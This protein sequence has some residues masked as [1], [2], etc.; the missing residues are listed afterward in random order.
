MDKILQKLKSAFQE[1]SGYTKDELKSGLTA[2]GHKRDKKQIDS[3]ASNPNLK[4]ADTMEYK[5]YK[6][7]EWPTGTR[8]FSNIQIVLKDGSLVG[9]FKNIKEAKQYIDSGKIKRHEVKSEKIESADMSSIINNLK[10]CPDNKL[11]PVDLYRGLLDIAYNKE[12]LNTN[13]LLKKFGRYTAKQWKDYLKQKKIMAEV[14]NPFEEDSGYTEE[15]WKKLD[16]KTKEQYLE[17]HPNSK[18]AEKKESVKP[19]KKD[20]SKDIQE[21]TDETMTTKEAKE[22]WRDYHTTDPILVDY[23]SFEDWYKESKE[24]G[25]IKDDKP[26]QEDNNSLE[27]VDDT[28]TTEEAKQYWKENHNSDP[29]LV[30]YDSFEDWYKESKE[31]GYIKDKPIEKDSSKDVHEEK[32]DQYEARKSFADKLSKKFGADYSKYISKDKPYENINGQEEYNDA[33]KKD[34]NTK[35]IFNLSNADME[36]SNKYN[37]FLDYIA[38]DPQYTACQEILIKTVSK[39]PKTFQKVYK[40]AEKLRDKKIQELGYKTRGDLAS[41]LAEENR[42]NQQKIIHNN[43][44][45]DTNTL[46]DYFLDPD[47]ENFERKY[48]TTNPLAGFE[49]MPAEKQKDLVERASVIRNNYGRSEYWQEVTRPA[50]KYYFKIDPNK[51][52]QEGLKKL[53]KGGMS[54]EEFCEKYKGSYIPNSGIEDDLLVFRKA[55][56]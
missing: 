46:R 53:L 49:G 36:H 32:K 13:E 43:P 16:K 11:P 6:S 21:E 51:V 10:H 7:A 40:I 12:H 1:D 31:N 9:H 38:N 3:A 19:A 39:D 48:G 20:S 4:G 2:A 17:E 47:L 30:D 23:D 35:K 44:L 56:L 18:Y 26:S 24:N 42:N 41:K 34:E 33:V 29:I 15:Q 37:Q 55:F 14:Y 50:I 5:G 54:A 27:E 52:P 28:M 45:V 22:Y 8:A 25:Y